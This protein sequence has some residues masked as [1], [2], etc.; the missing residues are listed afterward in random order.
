MLPPMCSTHPARRSRCDHPWHY[1]TLFTIS[2][3]QLAQQIRNRLQQNLQGSLPAGVGVAPSALISQMSGHGEVWIDAYG[4]PGAAGTLP[5][6][7]RSKR[8]LRC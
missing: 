8:W 1:A 2:G 5:E 7:A 4:L 3:E 6:H